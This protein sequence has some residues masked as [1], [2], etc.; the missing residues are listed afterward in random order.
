MS[1]IW[2]FTCPYYTFEISSN[3][4]KLLKYNFY[5]PQTKLREGNVFTDIYLFTRGWWVGTSHMYHGIALAYHEN[6]R[7]VTWRFL[8]DSNK[9][10]SNSNFDFLSIR[11]TLKI[12]KFLPPWYIKSFDP[13]SFKFEQRIN[14]ALDY[15]FL[16]SILSKC[17]HCVTPVWSG[18]ALKCRLR[19]SSS[20]ST[21]MLHCAWCWQRWF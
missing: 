11:G 15:S 13:K 21:Y 12:S 19:E 2:K 14:K 9:A 18:I 6:C 1:S 17:L 16:Q 3:K 5:L 4:L 20:A 10:R 7:P 8:G